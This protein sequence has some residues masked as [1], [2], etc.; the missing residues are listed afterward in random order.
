MP[1]LGEGIALEAGLELIRAHPCLVEGMIPSVEEH[2][3]NHCA[4]PD[5]Y[6]LRIRRATEYLRGHIEQGTA[7]S[8]YIGVL[9]LL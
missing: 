9:M 2:K 8:P 3:G 6:S 1:Y 5:I 7:L 4:S